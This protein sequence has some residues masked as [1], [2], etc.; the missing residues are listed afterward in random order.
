MQSGGPTAHLIHR[1]PGYEAGQTSIV[2]APTHAMRP[3]GISDKRGRRLTLCGTLAFPVA[4]NYSDLAPG[5][6]LTCAAVQ[7]VR[8]SA[9]PVRLSADLAAVRSLIDQAAIEASRSERSEHPVRPAGEILY[10]LIERV[11]GITDVNV[12]AQMAEAAA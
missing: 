2:G 11:A 10:D 5:A 8:P 3:A 7:T 6:C 9:Q 4:R 12:I 1:A